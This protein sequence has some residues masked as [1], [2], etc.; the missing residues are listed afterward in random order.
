MKKNQLKKHILIVNLYD[1]YYITN[2]AVWID[3][4]LA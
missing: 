4:E 1:T 2:I 3:R